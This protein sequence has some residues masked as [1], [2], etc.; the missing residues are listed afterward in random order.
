MD[1]A[2]AWLRGQRA[3][4]EERLGALVEASS[5]TLD[6]AGVDAAGVVVG[7][8]GRSWPLAVIHGGS[9]NWINT[10]GNVTGSNY[11]FDFNAHEVGH[12]LTQDFGFNHAFG[13]AGP[14]E[15]R[16]CVMS[17]MWYANDNSVEFDRWTPGSTRLPEEMTKGPGLAGCTRAGCGWARAL[18]RTQRRPAPRARR[19]SR[20]ACRT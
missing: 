12:N 11:R 14:Y 17:A 5:H 4:M 18:R 6:K 10:G 1:G 2:I 3:A 20:P 7:F 9:Q 19:S 8:D 15:N 13:P 16:F